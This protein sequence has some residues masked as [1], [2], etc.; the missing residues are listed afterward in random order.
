MRVKTQPEALILGYGQLLRW[1]SVMD[2]PSEINVPTPGL[3]GR[4]DFQFPPELQAM[5]AAGVSDARLEIVESAGHN[6]RL[7]WM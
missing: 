1:W 2:W 5:L 4:D 7:S 3:A 6:P